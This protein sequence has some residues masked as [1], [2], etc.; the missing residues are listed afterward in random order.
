[1]STL[2]KKVELPQIREY[3]HTLEKVNEG[4][5]KVKVDRQVFHRRSGQ[6]AQLLGVSDDGNVT[7]FDNVQLEHLVTEFV[8]REELD[9]NMVTMGP[10]KALDLT[11]MALVFWQVMTTNNIPQ[12]GHHILSTT[13]GGSSPEEEST[14]HP[15]S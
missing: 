9:G 2:K 11:K 7:Y 14:C 6:I 5:Y 4:Y 13:Y 1:M 15:L 12:V 8:S 10:M 3:Y